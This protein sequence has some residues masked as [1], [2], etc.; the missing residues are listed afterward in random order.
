MRVNIRSDSS[1]ALAWMF[2]SE[3]VRLYVKNRVDE[4]KGCENPADLLT[5][6]VTIETLLHSA[7]WWY[8]PPWLGNMH[9]QSN[10]SCIIYV[11]DSDI[12]KDQQILIKSSFPIDVNTYSCLDRLV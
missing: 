3:N 4:M 9:Y 12:V 10:L 2:T 6:R 11:D 1:I 8:R 7:H 5:R